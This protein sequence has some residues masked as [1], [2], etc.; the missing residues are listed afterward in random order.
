MHYVYLIESIPDPTRRYVGFSEDL[1][2]R[3]ADH[4]RGLN[5]STAA[6]RPWRLVAY[7]AF[8]SKQR[9]LDCERYLKSGSG[10]AFSQR[11]LW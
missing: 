5:T 10:H 4:N 1:R 11:H 6:D 3:F 7:L 8:A 2:Q 9:A